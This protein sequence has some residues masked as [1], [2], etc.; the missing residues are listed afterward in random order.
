MVQ[1]ADP[2]IR[3]ERFPFRE[4][5]THAVKS[6]FFLTCSKLVKRFEYRTIQFPGSHSRSGICRRRPVDLFKKF[7]QML[8]GILYQIQV[9]DLHQIEAIPQ[10]NHRSKNGRGFYRGT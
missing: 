8:V 6:G 10:V 1:M 3:I 7:D 9:L 5:G 4:E 2:G